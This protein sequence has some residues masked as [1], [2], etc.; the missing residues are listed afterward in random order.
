MIKELVTDKA[1]LSKRCEKATAEDAEVAQDLI[2]TI[3]TLDEAACLAAN[4]IGVTKAIGVWMD[5]D[6]QLHVVYNPR[7]MMGLQA[8]RVEETCMTLDEPVV[9]TRF[10]KAKVYFEELVDGELVARRHDY[11]GWESQMLQ[12][13]IDHCQG[14]LV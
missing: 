8:A 6:D 1:I 2:D 11:T 7:L 10:N 4:Q 14:K 5:D 12:H 13:I 9:V 3:Q